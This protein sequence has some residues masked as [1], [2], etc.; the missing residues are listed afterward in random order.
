MAKRRLGVGFIGSGFNARFHM[1]AW[2]RGARRRRAR[3]LEPQPE[4]RRGR[5]GASAQRSTSAPPRPTGRS[6]RWWPTPPSTRSGSADRTRRAS[7]TSRRS[8]D[9]VIRGKGRAQRHRL[10][11]AAGAQR[12]RG[13]AG[14]R[15]WRRRR[16]S[17]TAISRT[18]SSR[19]QVERGRE[20]LWARGA[21]TTGRPYL[22]R[23]AEEH[24]GPHMPWFWQGELQGGGVLNDMMCHSVLVVRHLLTKPGEPRSSVQAGGRSP[25]T[26]PAS[27]GPARST[28]KQ[29]KKTMGNDGRLRSSSPPRTSPA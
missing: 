13:E 29:L 16:D 27:S 23:A 4:E 25:G 2:Q 22:A 17:C 19:P 24:S 3:R 26:S 14:A 5:R 18:R 11:E 8:A 1:Q 7:R 28:S 10:R 20:L 12:R 9:A 21:A 15:R 6:P